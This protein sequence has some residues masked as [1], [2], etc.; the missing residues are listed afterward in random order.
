MSFDTTF[1]YTAAI[2]VID[3]LIATNVAQIASNNAKLA[4][5]SNLQAAYDASLNICCNIDSYN[6]HNTRLSV[7]N[8][9]Y[10]EL[11]ADMQA[12][13]SLDSGVKTTLYNFYIAFPT[14]KSMLMSKLVYNANQ[15]AIDC[16]TILAD[17]ISNDDKAFLAI[18]VYAKYREYFSNIPTFFSLFGTPNLA[19]S[20][21]F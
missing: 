8:D 3:G 12:L 20:N 15:M 13:S 19:I 17:T 7:Q 21:V 5:I 2:A 14:N 11:K 16:A 18:H 6:N 4:C 9:Y 1:D 10:T